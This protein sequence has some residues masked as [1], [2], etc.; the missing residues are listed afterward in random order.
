M[1]SNE[2]DSEIEREIGT[3][4]AVEIFAVSLDQDSIWQNREVRF[5]PELCLVRSSVTRTLHTKAS[6]NQKLTMP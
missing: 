2:C 1:L 6:S 3:K 5:E 4:L